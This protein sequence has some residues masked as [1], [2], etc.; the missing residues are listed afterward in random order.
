MGVFPTGSV[1]T[2]TNIDAAY[3]SNGFVSYLATL[4]YGVGL[5]ITKVYDVLNDVE[6]NSFSYDNVLGNIKIDTNDRR[7][8]FDRQYLITGF[9][10][11]DTVPYICNMYNVTAK[12]GIPAGIVG[13]K[14]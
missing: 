7:P 5:N 10:N 1:Q 12:T 8:N 2:I 14:F 13:P 3:Q 11:D 4:I 6:V 9:K